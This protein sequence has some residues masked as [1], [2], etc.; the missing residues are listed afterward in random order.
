MSFHMEIP[1]AGSSRGDGPPR[2]S[3]HRQHAEPTSLHG[4]DDSR[5]VPKYKAGERFEA[6]HDP[7]PE[8]NQAV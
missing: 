8:G 7:L 3:E 4:R 6:E 2:R 1:G 5:L